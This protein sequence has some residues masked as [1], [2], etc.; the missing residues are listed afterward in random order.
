MVRALEEEE[1]NLKARLFHFQD[2]GGRP[3]GH[4]MILESST[5]NGTMDDR[6]VR[7]QPS[8]PLNEQ[9]IDRQQIIGS[10]LNRHDK[11][12]GAALSPLSKDGQSSG[13]SITSPLFIEFICLHGFMRVF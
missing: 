6:I 11:I 7:S 12:N 13:K 10:A 5:T 9:P 2:E 8:R 4:S 1:E 3:L